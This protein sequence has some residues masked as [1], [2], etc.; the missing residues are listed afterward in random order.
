[1][2]VRVALIVAMSENRAIGRDGKLPWH[3]SE[4]LKYFKR[5]TLKKPV[6]MGRKTFDSIGRPLPDRENIVITRNQ[7]FAPDGVHVVHDL[8]SALDLAKDFAKASQIDEVMVIGGAQIYA[9]AMPMT[10]RIYLTEVDVVLDGDAFMPEFPADEW[11]A[12]DTSEDQ[13]DEKSGLVF[14]WIV[15]ER[16]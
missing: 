16:K 4:D 13:C 5:T 10:E 8:E 2:T 12:V 7:D 9:A 14:R 3:I 1:M 6:I 11:A 15:L